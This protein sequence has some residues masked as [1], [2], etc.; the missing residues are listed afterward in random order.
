MESVDCWALLTMD[1]W[2]MPYH[3]RLVRRL[4]ILARQVV[5]LSGDGGLAMLMGT[6]EISVLDVA[7]VSNG[8]QR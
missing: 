7:K 1:Q 4:V 3:K 2:R 6:R 8:T 5:A